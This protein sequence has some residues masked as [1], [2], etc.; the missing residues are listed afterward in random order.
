MQFAC[1]ISDQVFV[2]RVL[3]VIHYLKPAFLQFSFRRQDL[4]EESRR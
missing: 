2:Q 4:R 3:F 1:K